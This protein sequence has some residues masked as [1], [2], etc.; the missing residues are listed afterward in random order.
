MQEDEVETRIE[1]LES[2]LAWQEDAIAELSRQG[3]DKDRRIE[4]LESLTRTLSERLRDAA[5]SELG[6]A[7]E[8]RPP[9]Y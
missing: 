2:R 9:H 8:E 1:R 4:R 3:F 7:G 5:G 6:P